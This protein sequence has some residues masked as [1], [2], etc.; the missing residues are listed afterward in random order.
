MRE[1]GVRKAV[2]A[3]R[4]S[5]TVQYLCESMVM[6]LL[7]VITAVLI[8]DLLMPL[9]NTVTGKDL[10]LQA[11]LSLITFLAGVTFVTGL[12]SGLY[13]AVYLSRFSPAVVLKGKLAAASST[14]HSAAELFARKGLIVFQFII[15]IVFIVAVWVIYKQIDFVQYKHLGY[16]KDQLIYIKPEGYSLSH[17]ETFLNEARRIKGVAYASSIARTIV[18][19]HNT[20]MG[21]FNWE[22]KDPNVR[23]P[24]EIVN[25]NYD[26]IETLGIEMAEGRS[27]SR[28]H[29]TDSSA[30]VLN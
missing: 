28:T 16:D 25:C 15:T 6:S 11:S 26:L 2:G 3:G 5:L 22:G 13:P 18:G 4:T 12:F 9:F 8:A 14:L 23:I 1:V 29:S 7:A 20:T 19:S 24:F 17:L 30:I 21:Y 10:R 27:F